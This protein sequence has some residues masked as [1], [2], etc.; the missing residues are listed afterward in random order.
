MT[1]VVTSNL[2]TNVVITGD[3]KKLV[4]ATVA[5]DTGTTNGVIHLPLSKV[6]SYT[7]VVN[8]NVATAAFAT[9]TVSGAGNLVI[10][11]GADAHLS[12]VGVVVLGV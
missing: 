1:D 6:L 3:G 2:T 7:A 5:L 10:T 8:P 4:F 9:T 12:T 11:P